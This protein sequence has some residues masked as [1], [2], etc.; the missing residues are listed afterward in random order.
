M[1]RIGLAVVLALSLYAAPPNA[2]AQQARAKLVMLLTGSPAV[3]GP[4]SCRYSGQTADEVRAGHQSEDRQSA[5]PDDPSVDPDPS[6]RDHPVT[7]P[8]RRGRL[9]RA[10]L[11]FAGLPRPAYDR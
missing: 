7:M 8:D 10:A 6:R 4:E 9:L 11:G 3:S 2:G 5:G 1:R